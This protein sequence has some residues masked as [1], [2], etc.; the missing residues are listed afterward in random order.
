ML[1]PKPFHNFR[2][3][4]MR[5]LVYSSVLVLLTLMSL[6]TSADAFSR[7]THHSELPQNQQLTSVPVNGESQ[8]VPEPS[9]L[10]TLA[11]GIGLFAMLLARK[12]V[13]EQFAD[14]K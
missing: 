6:P 4:I 2:G 14:H 11:V 8:S 13:R 12:R 1:C 9:S 5:V 3:G 10:V 7:R